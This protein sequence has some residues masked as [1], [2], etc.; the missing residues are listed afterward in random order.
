[1]WIGGILAVIAAF[2]IGY[3]SFRLKGPYFVLVTLAFV[4]AIRRVFLNLKWLTNGAVGLLL[5]LLGDAPLEFQ[6]NGK[7]PYYYIGLTL[8]L[9]SIFVSYKIQGVKIGYYAN[10]VGGD[11]DVAESLG[12][13][14]TRYKLIPFAISAFFCA[15]GGTFYT[16]YILYLHPDGV[17]AFFPW[18]ITMIMVAILGGLHSIVGPAI[19]AALLI[20]LFEQIRVSFG[21]IGGLSIFVQGL[22]LVIVCLLI[23]SGIMTQIKKLVARARAAG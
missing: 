7:M 13:N 12:V 17:F 3:P 1:M 22:F 11:Q 14:S 15:I 5:P 4:E 19:G 10:A 9:A 2:L 16:Q 18:T 20:P 21:S 23:P 8:L 6:F